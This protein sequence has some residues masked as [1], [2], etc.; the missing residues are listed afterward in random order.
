VQSVS[1]GAE[2]G[3]KARKA[4]HHGCGANG[5][6]PKGDDRAT[7]QHGYADPELAYVVDRWPSLSAQAR[8]AVLAVLAAVPDS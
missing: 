5:G 2:V 4:A 6:A 3:S 8:A 1:G 7:K